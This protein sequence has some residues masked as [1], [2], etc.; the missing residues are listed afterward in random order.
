MK[1]F[2]IALRA[3]ST[4]SRLRLVPVLIEACAVLGDILNSLS[5]FEAARNLMVAVIPAVSFPCLIRAHM[6][7]HAD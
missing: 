3:A 6:L 2:S 5:E 4:S 1:G 7:L